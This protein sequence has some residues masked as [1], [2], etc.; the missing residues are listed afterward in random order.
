MIRP[1]LSF[2]MAALIGPAVA[3]SVAIP[4]TTRLCGCSSLLSVGLGQQ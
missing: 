4:S 3:V 2:L 1:A